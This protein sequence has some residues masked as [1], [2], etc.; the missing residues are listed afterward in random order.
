[1]RPL[2]GFRAFGGHSGADEK[3]VGYLIWLC[4]HNGISVERDKEAKAFRLVGR[5][6]SPTQI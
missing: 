1:M 4:G 3:S 6:Q 5:L 2:R